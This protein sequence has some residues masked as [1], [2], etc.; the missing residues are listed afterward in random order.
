MVSWRHRIGME[1]EP[2][3]QSFKHPVFITGCMRSGTSL[4]LGMLTRHPQ[5]LQVGTELNDVWTDIGG[6]SCLAGCEHKTA[7]DLD[8]SHA[9]DMTQ[10]FSNYLSRAKLYRRRMTR[11][12]NVAGKGTGRVRYDWR[13][14][15]PLNKSPHLIN[16]IAYVHAMYP[17]S[18]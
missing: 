13:N 12:R 4:L 2:S 14:L 9:H 6:G 8:L 11:L 10:Y 16:I 1:Q 18:K 15:V 3:G 5:L 17:D 7:G